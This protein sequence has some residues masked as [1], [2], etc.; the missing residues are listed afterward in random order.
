MPRG[1]VLF[2]LVLAVPALL[3]PETTGEVVLEAM[4]EF[5]GQSYENDPGRTPCGARPGYS[6]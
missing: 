3:A 2:L 1:L 5:L 6:S 4:R